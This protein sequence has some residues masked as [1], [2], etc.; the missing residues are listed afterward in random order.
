QRE[1][2]ISR[3]EE[4]VDRKLDLNKRS[5]YDFNRHKLNYIIENDGSKEELK[6]KVKDIY[7]DILKK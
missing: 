4:D 6:S 7:L 2:L 1:N 3:G 5:L